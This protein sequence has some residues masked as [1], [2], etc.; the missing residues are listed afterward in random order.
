MDFIDWLYSNDRFGITDKGDDYVNVKV[1]DG[2]TGMASKVVIQQARH[3]GYSVQGVD[4]GRRVIH[5]Q[6]DE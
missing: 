4:F 5:F 1:F 3:R 6:L 2:D